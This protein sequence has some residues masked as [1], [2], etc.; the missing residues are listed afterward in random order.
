MTGRNRKRACGMH[1]SLLRPFLTST[2]SF[3]FSNGGRSRYFDENGGFVILTDLSA[4]IYAQM[5]CFHGKIL[6]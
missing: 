3:E 1:I 4:A 6:K 5:A 2:A